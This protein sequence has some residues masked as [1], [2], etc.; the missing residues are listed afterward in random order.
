M[1]QPTRPEVPRGFDLED[2][3]PLEALLLSP[4]RVRWVALKALWQARAAWREPAA[5]AAMRAERD[6]ELAENLPAGFVIS[7]MAAITLFGALP[8]ELGEQS[9]PVLRLAWPLWALQIAP[10]VCAQIMAMV[11]A[12]SIAIQLTER[13]SGGGF[14]GTVQQRSMQ[15]A[16][17]SWPW[18][19]AHGAVCAASSCLMV[20]SSMLL[21]LLAGFAL[22]VGD[23]HQTASLLATQI[24]PLAW[25]RAGISAWLLGV[26]CTT[27]AVLYAWP[28][29]QSSRGGV[30]S[31]RLGLRATWVSSLTCLALGFVLHWLTRLAA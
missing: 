20:V 16:R 22:N 26:A 11:N 10:M 13:E 4:A 12:P 28:G 21:G 17:L 18:I 2:V 25:L 15:A 19:V 29:T 30:D 6:T 7:L 8:A 9:D 3:L 5:R 23:L 31:H 14:Q 1:T 24:G 27:A